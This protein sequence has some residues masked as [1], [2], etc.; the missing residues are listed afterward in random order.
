[1]RRLALASCAAGMLFTVLGC[2]ATPLDQ[3]RAMSKSRVEPLSASQIAAL[4]DWHTDRPV[5]TF[6]RVGEVR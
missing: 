3:W 1:M 5:A 6:V 2:Q 4:D